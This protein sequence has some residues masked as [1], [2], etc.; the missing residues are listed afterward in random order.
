MSSTAAMSSM[1]HICQQ[2]Q[3]DLQP[4]SASLD[5]RQLCRLQPVEARRRL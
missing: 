1:A 2:V 5:I 4:A 3:I